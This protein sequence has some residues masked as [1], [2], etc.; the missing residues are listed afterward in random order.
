MKKVLVFLLTFSL[1]I[2]IEPAYAGPG[3]K[4]AQAAFETTWGKIV[5]GVLTIIF[6]PIVIWVMVKEYRA[7]RRARQDLRFMAQH[8]AMFEWLQIQA[9]AKECFYKI[10]SSWEKEDVSDAAEW[11]TD[12]YWRNQQMVYLERWK[13]DGLQNICEVKKIRTIKPLLFIH[14]NWGGEH[15]ESTIAISI[16]ADMRDYLQKR[17][18]GQIVEG[19]K[20]LKEVETIW[21]FT[22]SQGKWRVSDIDEINMSLEFAK[23]GAEQPPIESTV[24]ARAQ[25]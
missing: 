7:E 24:A 21:T 12:W 23:V 10:H 5:L 2:L 20:K 18:S 16:K 15:E 25:T 13:R 9:R 6:L 11:M 14:R 19:S 1:L 3:G 8:S 4:I 17:S 22:L